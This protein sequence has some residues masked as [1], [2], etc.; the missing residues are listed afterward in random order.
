MLSCKSLPTYFQRTS[1]HEA[2]ALGLF[3]NGSFPSKMQ[4][5]QSKIRHKIILTD[6]N[7]VINKKQFPYP[8]KY[9]VAWRK[10][11]DQHL[12]GGRIR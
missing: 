9:L 10:L 2:E 7:A 1:Q 6:P 3:S 12:K 11:L 8:R 4:E 5:I